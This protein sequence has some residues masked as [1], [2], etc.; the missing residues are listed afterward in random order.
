MDG[1]LLLAYNYHLSSGSANTSSKYNLIHIITK[2]LYLKY[3]ITIYKTY[4]MITKILQN[5]IRAI[6]I[7]CR[8]AL[9]LASEPLERVGIEDEERL[10]YTAWG[11]GNSPWAPS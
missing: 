8:R 9:G 3:I 6:A 4:Y 2:S 10:P 7:T 5:L 11:Q 1:H